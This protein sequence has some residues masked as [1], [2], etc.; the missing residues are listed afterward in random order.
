[1]AI[2]KTKDI[3]T[4]TKDEREAKIKELQLELAKGNVTANRANAKTKELKRALARLFTFNTAFHKS[5]ATLV[6]RTRGSQS[7]TSKKEVLKK[8]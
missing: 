5:E 2:L 4:M 6:A 8:E 7:A 1:M 3:K